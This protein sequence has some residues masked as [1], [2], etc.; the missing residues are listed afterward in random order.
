M[1]LL[2]HYVISLTV[3]AVVM[4]S[5]GLFVFLKSPKREINWSFALYYS[6]IAWW[7]LFE[8]YSISAPTK[9]LGLWTWR[10]N[11][12]GVI[13]IPIF[14][15]HFIYSILE[16]PKQNRRLLKLLYGIGY[17]LAA[18]NLTSLLIADVTPKFSFKHMVVPGPFYLAFVL[19]WIA[20]ITYGLV[21]LYIAYLKSTGI[22]RNQ[23]RYFWIGSL[24]GYLGGPFN[25]LPAF[26]IE[27][28]PIM[29]FG[30]YAVPFYSA[31]VTYAIVKYRLMDIT[32]A[33]TK[34]ASLIITYGVAVLLPII[35]STVFRPGLMEVMGEKWWLGPIIIYSIAITFAP[36]AY[37]KLQTK[38][39]NQMMKN[40]KHRHDIINTATR[41][42]PLIRS[43]DRILNWIVRTLRV[44]FGITHA[45]IYMFDRNTSKYRCCVTRW[46]RKN[47]ANI[48]FGTVAI[49]SGNSLAKYLYG[50]RRPVVYEE[51]RREYE[52]KRDI[53]TK[54]IR[55]TMIR[56]RADIILPYL[57]EDELIGFLVLGAKKS[58][59]MFSNEDLNVLSNMANHSALAIEN[60]QFLKEREEMQGKLREAETLT[61]IRDLLGSFNH[62]LYNLLSPIA[63]SLYAYHHTC[64]A[65]VPARPYTL[66]YHTLYK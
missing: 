55:E 2:H 59:E 6:A 32:L 42:I 10:I 45:S 41:N 21:K 12:M 23:L 24:I 31:I 63:G 52:D 49:D 22:R 38:A 35:L 46:G 20:Q 44:T 9:S 61:T 13:F 19:W 58:G 26:N 47:E 17:C 14:F 28:F 56:L 66:R 27:I 4:F 34:T 60:A 18:L 53:F 33:I 48:D 54:E 64:K 15:V 25:F 62:E 40:Q 29:P 43:F 7:S 5:M 16:V 57:V 1:N 50:S 11:H 65:P 37:R 8:A 30:T 39:E 51:I 3:T 36:F